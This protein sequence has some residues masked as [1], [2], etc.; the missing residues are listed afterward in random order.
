V[1][2]PA[3]G[4]NLRR[5][6]MVG[7]VATAVGCAVLLFQLRSGEVHDGLGSRAAAG[8]LQYVPNAAEPAAQP[9]GLEQVASPTPVV[10]PTE[11]DTTTPSQRTQVAP[12]AD[13]SSGVAR[14]GG[15]AREPG[16]KSDATPAQQ[17]VDSGTALMRQGRLGLA[18]GMF[19]KALQTAP[20]NANAMAELVRVHLARRDGV[21]ALRWANRLVGVQPSS[22]ANQLLLGDALKLRGDADGAQAA[23]SRAARAGNATARE[24]LAE[25]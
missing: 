13:R 3:R 5:A 1:A 10:S 19:L 16:S 18:E 20:E 22:G 23:W 25:E 14:S 2:P 15:S 24:R 12:S 17:L 8:A 11:P 4:K 21:E 7:G 9:G 6:L